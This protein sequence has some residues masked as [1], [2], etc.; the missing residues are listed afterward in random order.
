MS[1]DG[2]DHALAWFRSYGCEFCHAHRSIQVCHRSVVIDAVEPRHQNRKKGD[3]LIAWI[4]YRPIAG[5][6]E[7]C[8]VRP[9]G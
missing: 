5:L 3:I 2:L 7:W 1:S 8:I 4:G 6:S 9:C